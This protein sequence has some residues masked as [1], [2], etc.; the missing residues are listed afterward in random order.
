[1]GGNSG[2]LQAVPAEI[3]ACSIGKC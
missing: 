3:Y 1:M 2:D